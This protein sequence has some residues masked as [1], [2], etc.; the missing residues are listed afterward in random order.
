MASP[1]PQLL[2]TISLFSVSV[3]LLLFFFALFTSLLYLSIYHYLPITIDLSI[4]K[5][6]DRASYLY[7]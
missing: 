1:P 5:Y 4:D 6:I 7:I 2:V 3:I